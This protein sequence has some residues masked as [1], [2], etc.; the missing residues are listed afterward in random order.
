[1]QRYLA[2]LFI[3]I[4]ALLT[5]CGGQPAVLPF[6]QLNAHEVVGALNAAGATVQSPVNDMIVGR[7][8]P[9]TF[10]ERVVFQI[11]SIAPEGGQIVIFRTPADLQA[12]EQ[13]INTLRAD[14]DNRRSVIYVYVHQNALLQLNA[15]L[16][17]NEAAVYSDAFSSIG[18]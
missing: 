17:P 8:A 6:D 12:W 5:A 1:M 14:P 9:N 11:P 10:T 7:D 18:G 2:A 15:G 13:Y 16:L 4:T 3:A